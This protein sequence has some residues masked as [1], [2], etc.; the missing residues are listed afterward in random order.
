MV[1]SAKACKTWPS[2]WIHYVFKWI[3]IE[4][5]S[6]WITSSEEFFEHSVWIFECKSEGSFV[7]KSSMAFWSGSKVKVKIILMVSKFVPRV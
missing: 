1:R 2:E 4:Q 7:G 5:F 3:K 6:K